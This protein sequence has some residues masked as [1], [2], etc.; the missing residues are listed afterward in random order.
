MK[1]QGCGYHVVKHIST[2]PQ[3]L[4]VFDGR[5]IIQRTTLFVAI[6]TVVQKDL[7]VVLTSSFTISALMWW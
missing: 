1:N 2:H 3:F 6:Q 4:M 5:Q 7:I